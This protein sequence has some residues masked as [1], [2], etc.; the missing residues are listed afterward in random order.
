[1]LPADILQDQ[2]TSGLALYAEEGNEKTKTNRKRRTTTNQ[3][4][5]LMADS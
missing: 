2:I 1:M 4:R 3:T 5:R